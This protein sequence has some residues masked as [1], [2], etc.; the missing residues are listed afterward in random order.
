[1]SLQDDMDTMRKV[2]REQ[3]PQE[4]TDA[5]REQYIEEIVGVCDDGMPTATELANIMWYMG[6]DSHHPG[7]CINRGEDGGDVA[8]ENACPECEA[9]LTELGRKM[10]EAFA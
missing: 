4:W 5:E 8:Y 1:M 10:L 3:G 7:Q 2:L 9:D 6:A